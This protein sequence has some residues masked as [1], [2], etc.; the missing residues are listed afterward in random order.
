MNTKIVENGNIRE[1][2][3][4]NKLLLVTTDETMFERMYFDAFC[5]SHASAILILTK[6][7]RPDADRFIPSNMYDFINVVKAIEY[8]ANCIYNKVYHDKDQPIYVS[9]LYN[10]SF[11][12]RHRPEIAGWYNKTIDSTG[13]EM[14][15]NDMEAKKLSPSEIAMGSY[16]KLG[17]SG[18]LLPKLTIHDLEDGRHIKWLE[19]NSDQYEEYKKLG[20]FDLIYSDLSSGIKPIDAIFKCDIDFISIYENGFDEIPFD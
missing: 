12:F 13:K 6:D 1:Y 18:K 9:R 7:D 11:I 4:D 8:T 5:N 2:Y 10:T 14:T 15:D 20:D 17:Y 19:L 3:V 16:V